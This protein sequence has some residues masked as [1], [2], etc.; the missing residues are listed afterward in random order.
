MNWTWFHR[1]GSAPHFYPLAGKLLPWC[2]GITLLLLLTGTVWGLAFAPMDYLQGESYRIIFVH[3]PSAWLSMLAYA[4]MAG[5]G[6]VFLVWKIKLADALSQACAPIGASFTLLALVT[7]SLW[8]KPMWGTWWEW[9]ARL[10]SELILLFLYL[11]VMA[12]RS[13]IDD[14]RRA[15]RAAAA[16]SLVGV[17]NLP[18]IHFSV[19]WWNTLHQPA[20]ISK[21]GGPSIH[22]SMLAPLLIMVAGFTL[23]FVSVVL[24]RVQCD[25]LLREKHSRW[26]RELME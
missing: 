25:I 8:G 11:G 6:L 1:L 9:D 3:V 19:Q 12:L 26:L 23:F 16:L 7:G 4:V 20:S 14:S 15:G 17:I 18:V 21:I 24:L 5:A 2:W 13:A 10:T 22:V